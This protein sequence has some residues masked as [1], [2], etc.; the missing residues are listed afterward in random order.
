MTVLLPGLQLGLALGVL[1][2]ARS[3][4]RLARLGLRREDMLFRSLAT[5]DELL[6]RAVSGTLDED[7]LRLGLQLVE[8]GM[9]DEL[10]AQE[11]LGSLQ[12]VPRVGDPWPDSMLASV[13][14]VAEA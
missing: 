9:R 12:R 11:Q 3:T 8:V 14:D 13:L 10:A 6:R 2:I 5:Y 4:M 7:E 1:F